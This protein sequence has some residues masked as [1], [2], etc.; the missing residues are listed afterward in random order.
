M[1]RLALSAALSL[2]LLGAAAASRPPLDA[3]LQA[4]HAGDYR[5]AIAE[6][7]RAADADPAS[8][9]PVYMLLFS[10]WSQRAFEEG[11]DAKADPVFDSAYDEL[12][13]VA[14][15]RLA[16]MPNDAEAL[17]AIGG[18]QVLRAQVEALRGNFFRAG[19]EA[20]QGKKALEK[21][22]AISPSLETALFPLGALNYYADRVPLIVK[23]LRPFL[24][25]P[26]GDVPLGLKQIRSVADGNGRFRTE[27]RLLF[28]L[29]CAD[30]Y[31]QRYREAVA[32]FERAV[33]ASPDSPVVRAALASIQLKLG[34]DRAAETSFQDG[35]QRAGG[36]GAERGRQRRWLWL[37][38]AEARLMG[39][40]LSEAEEALR[41]AAAEPV[42]NTSSLERA[43]RRLDEEMR[44][45][46]EVL[47]GFQGTGEP[48]REQ[49]EEAARAV[50]GSASAWLLLGARRLDAG[51]ATGARQALDQA[52]SIL[53]ADAPAW[54]EGGVTLLHGDAE[55]ALG[56]G[57]QAHSDW[58]RAAGIK[59]FRNAER[60]RMKLQDP[61]E[62]SEICVP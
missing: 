43:R 24:F 50:P 60:A 53:P 9:D 48:T 30:R 51:D 3:G 16:K 46:R 14:N 39:W 41:K 8:P 28:G 62:G 45:K 61:G 42:E 29:L 32:Q 19:R 10:R 49:A 17:A 23:G 4:M 21:A 25:I 15:A 58:E 35:L 55:A 5:G 26:G 47:P 36:D 52:R 22:L 20:R 18:A 37:G 40:R 34:E 13:R 12:L 33:E 57:K 27:A 54:L 59:R 7:R 56:R 11:E 31:Q 2:A 44:L 1:P 38:T 6:F